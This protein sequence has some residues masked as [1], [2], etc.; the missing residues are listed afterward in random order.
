M[1]RKINKMFQ[2]L[3]NAEVF[4]KKIDQMIKTFFTK[5]IFKMMWKGQKHR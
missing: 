2:E 1:L 4:K 3:F 5:N